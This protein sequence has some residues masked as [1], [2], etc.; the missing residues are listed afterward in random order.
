M[1]FFFIEKQLEILLGFAR[2]ME[3]VPINVTYS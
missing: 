1:V 2:K 3:I